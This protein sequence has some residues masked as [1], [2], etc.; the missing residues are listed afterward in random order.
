MEAEIDQK[1][2]VPGFL[3]Q[4]LTKEDDEKRESP[5]LI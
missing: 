4:F 1:T 3:T 5:D 2:F